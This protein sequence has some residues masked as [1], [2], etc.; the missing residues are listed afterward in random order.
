MREPLLIDLHNAAQLELMT[1]TMR[2][3]GSQRSA[4]QSCDRSAVVGPTRA[5]VHMPR[6]ANDLCL[7]FF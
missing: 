1:R 7:R 4:L 3:K 5:E 6:R 2:F